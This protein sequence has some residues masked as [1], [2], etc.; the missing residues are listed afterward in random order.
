MLLCQTM[1]NIFSQVKDLQGKKISPC[2]HKQMENYLDGATPTRFGPRPR[3][4]ER[5]PSFSKIILRERESEREGGSERE[6]E[7]G[8]ERKVYKRGVTIL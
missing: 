6:G 2:V 3:N 1:T 8:E 4:K 7:T 5:G